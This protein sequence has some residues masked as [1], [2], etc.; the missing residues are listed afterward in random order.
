M[1]VGLKNLLGFLQR[2][3]TGDPKLKMI[4]PWNGIPLPS[5]DIMP[6]TSNVFNGKF[7]FFIQWNV[8]LMQYADNIGA[9]TNK[10]AN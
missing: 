10:I 6:G 5:I 9:N 1:E 3:E 2:H 7:E 8:A 4:C